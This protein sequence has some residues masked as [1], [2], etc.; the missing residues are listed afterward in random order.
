AGD[1]PS[2][3]AIVAAR[4][5]LQLLLRSEIG[6]RLLRAVDIICQHLRAERDEGIGIGLKAATVPR[7]TCYLMLNINLDDPDAMKHSV[8][9]ITEYVV[10]VRLPTCNRKEERGRKAVR[11]RLLRQLGVKACLPQAVQLIEQIRSACHNEFVSL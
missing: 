5:N 9:P 11:R 1:G 7:I 10:T 4:G 8:L 2:D 6:E 3:P